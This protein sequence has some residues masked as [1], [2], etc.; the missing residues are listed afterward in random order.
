MCVVCAYIHDSRIPQKSIYSMLVP[1]V[2][3]TY[4]HKAI[5]S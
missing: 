4:I 1:V 5:H 3:L 2:E